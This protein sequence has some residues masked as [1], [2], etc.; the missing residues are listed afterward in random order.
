[1]VSN[2]G[3][4]GVVA[5]NSQSVALLIVCEVVDVLGLLAV[6]RPGV[7]W[8]ALGWSSQWEERWR[9]LDPLSAPAVSPFSCLS[10]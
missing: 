3:P 4:V 10:C 1:M 2:S 5:Q 7:A 6:R 8:E 9:H